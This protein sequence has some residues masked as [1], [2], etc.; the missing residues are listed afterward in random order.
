MHYS[1][2]FLMTSLMVAG[3]AHAANPTINV[4]GKITP[5]ACSASIVGGED[6]VWDPISHNSLSDTTFTVLEAKPATLKVQ[7]DNGLKTH[8]AFWAK[9]ANATSAIAGVMVP[10]TSLPNGNAAER[11]FGIGM[12]PVTNKKIGNFTLIAKSSSFD[13]TENSTELGFG[14][15][16][17]VKFSSAV[18]GW[19]Y[20][21]TE[22]W[23][24]LDV[25]THLPAEANTFT[26]AFDVVPQINKK[27]EI[28]NA[29]EV[30]FAG[31]AQFFVRYF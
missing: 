27:S 19:G 30:P 14:G 16:G 4:S 5:P 7:C 10:G 17:A 8:M 22:D 23:T 9:D 28:T 29:Q 20:K 13:S 25:G 18:F 2:L 24:V 31:T 3:S 12:D 1:K 6:L 11:I 21:L 26:F 15:R